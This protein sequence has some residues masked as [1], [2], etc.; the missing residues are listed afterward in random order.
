MCK[1]EENKAA[2]FFFSFFSFIFYFYLSLGDVSAAWFAVYKLL[3]C[4]KPYQQNHPTGLAGAGVEEMKTAVNPD[5][6]IDS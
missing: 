6:L 5:C 4:D 1:N 3:L 2:N